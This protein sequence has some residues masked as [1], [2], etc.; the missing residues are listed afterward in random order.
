MLRNLGGGVRPDLADIDLWRSTRLPM[1]EMERL[2]AELVRERRP[3]PTWEELDITII[4][5][6]LGQIAKWLIKSNYAKLHKLPTRYSILLIM[7]KSHIT[8]LHIVSAPKNVGLARYPIKQQLNYS[9][10][11]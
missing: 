1:L 5:M 7:A 8:L 4:P 9:H 11:Y 3:P 2:E 10:H 6:N